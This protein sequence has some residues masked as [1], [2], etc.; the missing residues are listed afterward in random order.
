LKNNFFL[1]PAPFRS[2]EVSPALM[3]SGSAT[4]F[5]FI[6]ACVVAA[7]I[8]AIIIVPSNLIFLFL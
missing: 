3:L 4:P 7:I 6:C 1:I 2:H 5:T 8:T